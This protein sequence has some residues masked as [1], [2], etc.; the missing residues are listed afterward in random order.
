MLEEKI[1]FVAAMSKSLHSVYTRES[2]TIFQVLGLGH[3]K[4]CW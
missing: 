1:D 4:T 3:L 2:G